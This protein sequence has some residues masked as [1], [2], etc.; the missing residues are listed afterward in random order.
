MDFKLATFMLLTTILYC[1]VGCGDDEWHKHY[2]KLDEIC[3]LYLEC[4]VFERRD[5]C[6]RTWSI[7]VLSREC[8]DAILKTSCEGL[9]GWGDF[10]A[11]CW[12]Q[13]SGGAS[14]TFECKGDNLISCSESREYIFRCE[15]LCER[16][17][18]KYTG[19]CGKEY[20]G[21]TSINDHCW[22]E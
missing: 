21:E 6:E 1:Q 15:G 4:G 18:E 7:Y 17:F 14:D 3:D 8:V 11:A 13:C 2:G 10:S 9:E 16:E 22:C 5:G 12:D 19:V 20:K